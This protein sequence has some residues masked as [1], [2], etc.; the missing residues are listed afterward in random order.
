MKVCLT[1]TGDSLES[2][3]DSRFGRCGYFIFL[4]TEES[5]KY[6]SVENLAANAAHG[7]G[8]QAS[9]FVMEKK[10]DA[11]ITGNIGP[12]ASSVLS[13]AGIKVYSFAGFDGT[14]N[15]ALTAFRDNKLKPVSGPTVGSHFG[16]SNDK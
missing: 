4:D 15:D 11:V 12:N 1:S 7:A 13:N 3:L 6:E 14:V 2:K 10:P 16:I 9:Q 8:I 5:E